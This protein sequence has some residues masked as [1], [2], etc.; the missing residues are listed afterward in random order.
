MYFAIKQE[1]SIF[2]RFPSLLFF[3]YIEYYLNLPKRKVLCE[4]RGKVTFSHFSELSFLFDKLIQIDRLGQFTAA[5]RILMM[6]S[7]VSYT[8]SETC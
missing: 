1:K 4:N 2:S 8:P 6:I 5:D 7:E 3:R